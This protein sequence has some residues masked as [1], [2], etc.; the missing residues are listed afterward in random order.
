[1][2]IEQLECMGEFLQ[3]IIETRAVF[4]DRYHTSDDYCAREAVQNFFCRS[5][6]YL[7]IFEGKGINAEGTFEKYVGA[8]QA[9]KIQ[10][11]YLT[12]LE[13]VQFASTSSC[14]NFSTFQIRRFSAEELADI[15]GNP[16]NRIFYPQSVIDVERLQGY[17]FLSTTRPHPRPHPL[18]TFATLDWNMIGRIKPEYQNDSKEFRSG[19]P[20]QLLAP[21]AWEDGNID[22]FGRGA[23]DLPLVLGFD[24]DLISFPAAAPSLSGLPAGIRVDPDTGEESEH[25]AIWM[26]LD[27]EETDQLKAFVLRMEKLFGVLKPQAL[28]WDFLKRAL[29]YFMKASRSRG[30]D[31][32]GESE[33][34]KGAI[35]HLKN[36]VSQ[37]LRNKSIKKNHRKTTPRKELY[38]FRN[39]LVHGKRFN[40]A[41]P[42]LRSHLAKARTLAR[43]TLLWSLHYLYT[44]QVSMSKSQEGA[45]VPSRDQLLKILDEYEKTQQSPNWLMNSLPV[46]FPYVQG[47][48]E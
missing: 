7:G 11:T 44:V 36:R 5:G 6:F 46:G 22:E 14:M 1:M 27:E 8:F 40:D 33:N 13:G 41:D 31:Q 48:I 3:L 4:R 47:W 42:V 2:V 29:A 28:G 39:T 32:I 45:N 17:W 23:C 24:N 10:V 35:E 43:K 9:D 20:H 30:M 15:A 16:I 26:R 19:S 37:V 12:L 18:R 38:E 21:F 34:S 25:P